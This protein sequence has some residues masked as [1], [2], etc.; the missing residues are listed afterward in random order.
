MM[1]RY[2][3][4]TGG[5]VIRELTGEVHNNADMDTLRKAFWAKI[6]LP[7]RA[8]VTVRKVG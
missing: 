8:T 4:E 7:W 6:S 1:V 2:E 5:R 3:L